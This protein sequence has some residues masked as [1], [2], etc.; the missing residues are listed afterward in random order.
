MALTS[1]IEQR[2]LNRFDELLN[3]ANEL[4]PMMETNKRETAARRSF[5]IGSY[6]YKAEYQA[7]VEK[8][9]V[10]VRTLVRNQDQLEELINDVSRKNNGAGSVRSIIG[11]SVGT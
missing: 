6:G 3:E 7:L 8:Y 10:L 4:I 2:L 5:R 11:K 1:E 9:Q